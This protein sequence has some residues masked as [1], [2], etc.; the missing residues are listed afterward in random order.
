MRAYL[1]LLRKLE[2]MQQRSLDGDEEPGREQ[3]CE[4]RRVCDPM[5]R[6]THVQL[7]SCSISARDALTASDAV[8]P[9]RTHAHRGLGVDGAWSSLNAAPFESNL[10]D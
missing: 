8:R 6:A 2:K 4:R 7:A 9:G 10:V 3:R 5:A 1:P